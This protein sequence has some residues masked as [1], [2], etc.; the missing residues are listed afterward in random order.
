MPWE[1]NN[2]CNTGSLTTGPSLPCC[3][4]HSPGGRQ[5]C[6]NWLLFAWYM[7][8]LLEVLSCLGLV[9]V[10]QC[11]DASASSSKPASGPGHS[12][13]H[14]KASWE[15]GSQLLSPLSGQQPSKPTLHVLCLLFLSRF[16][17]AERMIPFWAQ[18]M[19]C[20]L[21]PL[22]SL[23]CVGRRVFTCLFV[24][25]F[26]LFRATPAAYGCSQDRVTGLN[27]S[28]SCWPP[29]QPQQHRIQASS[30]PYTTAYSNSGSL[31]HWARP[32][33]K[34]TSLWILV[35]FLTCCTTAGTPIICIFK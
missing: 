13:S 33:I 35:R 15:L 26:W 12:R 29:P 30:V 20:F 9:L 5:K 10:S 28:R 32:G 25:L 2:A 11:I 7:K 1:L 31:T 3:A 21:R 4:K 17:F 19:S 34:S 23:P 27:R 16:L 6:V 22:A 14:F 24:C 8:W 18:P